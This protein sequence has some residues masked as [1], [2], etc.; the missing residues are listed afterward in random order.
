VNLIF[1]VSLLIKTCWGGGDVVDPRSTQNSWIWC[2]NCKMYVYFYVKIFMYSKFLA[3]EKKK[4]R[5]NVMCSTRA[6][7]KILKKNNFRRPH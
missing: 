7:V 3:E 1:A 4:N 6:D 2:S 5:K